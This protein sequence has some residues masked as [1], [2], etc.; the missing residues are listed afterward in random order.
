MILTVPGL[1]FH[2]RNDK[3]RSLAPAGIPCFYHNSDR[4]R[5]SDECTE[6]TDKKNLYSPTCRSPPFVFSVQ[7]EG[8]ARC[9]CSQAVTL[10]QLT[11]S[12]ATT[13]EFSPGRIYFKQ[14]GA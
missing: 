13:F 2:L 12:Q 9:V 4:I 10:G 14:N 8:S 6:H 11:A 3:A 1:G 7:R 5:L